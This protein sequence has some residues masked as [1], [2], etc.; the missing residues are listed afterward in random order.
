MAEEL[1]K[2]EKFFLRFVD[3]GDRL[4]GV[5]V[6]GSTFTPELKATM[7]AIRQKLGVSTNRQA[8]DLAKERQFI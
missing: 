1:T 5:D 6:E 2:E 4:R 8:V 3:Q 7:K